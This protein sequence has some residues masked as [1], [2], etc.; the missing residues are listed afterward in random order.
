MNRVLSLMCIRPIQ[1]SQHSVNRCA[2]SYFMRSSKNARRKFFYT[3]STSTKLRTRRGSFS[4]YNIVNNVIHACLTWDNFLCPIESCDFMQSQQR[5]PCSLETV[6]TRLVL[7]D[8]ELMF[9]WKT[10]IFSESRRILKLPKVV[11]NIP[12]NCDHFSPIAFYFWI[13]I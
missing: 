4:H 2:R 12:S 8:H 6:W 11:V 10:R 1:F 7:L 13:L 3:F 9:V 5:P